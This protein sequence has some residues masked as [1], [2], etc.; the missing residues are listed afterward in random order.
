LFKLRII[1]YC[2]PELVEDH[3]GTMEAHVGSSGLANGK[4]DY[5]LGA[6]DSY[7]RVKENHPWVAKDHLK[8]MVAPPG[9]REDLTGVRVDIP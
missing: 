2:Y 6:V 8:V 4:L 7:Y 3:P 9:V 1:K 5:P